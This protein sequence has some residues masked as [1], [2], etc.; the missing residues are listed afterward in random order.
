MR[1]PFAKFSVAAAVVVA[2]SLIVSV[3]TGTES[4]AL[5]DVLARIQRSQSFRYKTRTTEE[6]P[7][8]GRTVTES[9]V[10][11]SNEYGMKVDQTTTNPETNEKTSLQSYLLPAEKKA[12]LIRR[13][14]KQYGVVPWDDATLANA[15]A[16]HRDPRVMLERLL[17]CKY[18][19][20]GP[21]RIDG[22]EVQGFETTDPAFLAGVAGSVRVAFWV[23]ARTW[24]PVRSETEM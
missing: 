24:L 17:S 1:S 6:H 23:G 20:L 7:T 13:D 18:R 9:T 10:L 3:W 15:Q 19:P 14:E 22:R 5:A 11:V 12:I 21:S 2:G 8:Q 16:E 4:V